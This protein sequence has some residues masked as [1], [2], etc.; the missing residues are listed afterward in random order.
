MAMHKYA[1][2]TVGDILR[3]KKASVRSAPL[4]PGTPPWGELEVMVWEDVDLAAR[5]NQPGFRMIRKLLT[6]SRFDR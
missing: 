6:D 1:G 3:R 5:S 4:P 2:M